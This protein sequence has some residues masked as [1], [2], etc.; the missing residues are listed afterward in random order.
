M[1]FTNSTNNSG[2]MDNPNTINHSIFVSDTNEKNL[3]RDGIRVTGT[4][5]KMETNI[6]RYNHLFF[7][8]SLE[9]IEIV[10]EC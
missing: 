2:K 8:C 1:S 5:N 6:A 10:L 4:K 9:N 3:E 7:G